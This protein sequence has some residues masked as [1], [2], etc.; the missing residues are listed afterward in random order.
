MGWN[1]FGQYEITIALSALS[2]GCLKEFGQK[3]IL[4]TDTKGKEL[5]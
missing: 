2:L 1:A 4:I 3:V 5:L